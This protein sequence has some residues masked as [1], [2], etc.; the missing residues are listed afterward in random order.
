[1][2]VQIKPWGNGQGIRL[3]KATLQEAGLSVND[4][5]ELTID[6]SEII[7]TKTFRHR[8]L[9]ERAAEYGGVLNFSEE[10]DWGDPVGNEVF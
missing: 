7:L 10:I 8:S 9:K 4:Y 3:S 5:L 6:H 2:Q 1:M